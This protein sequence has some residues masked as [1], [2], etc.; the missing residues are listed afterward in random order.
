MDKSFWQLVHD[1]WNSAEKYLETASYHVREMARLFEQAEDD[2][3]RRLSLH[4]LK[5]IREARETLPVVLTE[6]NRRGEETSTANAKKDEPC[7]VLRLRKALIK[8]G[9]SRITKI[10]FAE[11]WARDWRHV[12]VNYEYRLQDVTP[13]QNDVIAVLYAEVRESESGELT[14]E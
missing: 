14:V 2:Q 5:R 7:Y 13:D 8:A 1:N 10:D 12:V 3:G 9:F 11:H 4:V 6:E